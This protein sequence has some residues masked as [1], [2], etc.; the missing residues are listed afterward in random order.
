MRRRPNSSAVSGRS[1]GRFLQADHPDDDG[2]KLFNVAISRACKHL[3]AIAN[4]TYL[5]GQLPG[6]AF[7]RDILFKMQSSGQVIDARE[8]LTLDPSDL[9]ELGNIVDIDLEAK[10]TGLFGQNNFDIVFRADI[11]QAKNS[12]V[13]FS[14]FITPERVGSYGDLFRR[15][16]LEDVK[17]RCATRP[18]QY[19]GSI[20]IERGREALDALEGIG[21]T[22]DCR[23]EI[24]QK[25]AIIDSK[26][27]WFGSLNPL[28][29]TARS[30]EIMMRAVAPSFAAELARQI[31]V[32][33]ARRDGQGAATGENPR[34]GRCGHRTYY[35][36]SRK[37]ARAFFA[38]EESDCGWL[39]DASREVSNR[40]VA[41]ADNLPHE[42]PPC[43]KCGCK[44]RRRQGPYGPFYSCLRYPKCDGKINIRQ[45][46]E[47]MVGA[48][49]S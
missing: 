5:D 34:C 30:D 40:D 3:V 26:I 20:P 32:R 42:G 36:Y 28:S 46:M 49:H 8:I 25:I 44:M 38:C 45:A 4:L 23:R 11:E 43:P 41:E 19:N 10:R 24:H 9:P 21:A 31:A 14:G 18:P 29:H 2:A 15:K 39:Q 13:I 48:D 33:S 7:L 27:V 35:F 37:K 12:V 22:V 16:I 6:G 47:M 17:L 1:I